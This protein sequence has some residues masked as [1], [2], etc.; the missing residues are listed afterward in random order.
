M[1]SV[2][3][4]EELHKTIWK[5]A[6]DL[7]GSVDGWDFKSYV[8][9]F[10]FYYF[11]CENLKSYVLNSFKQD[12]ENLSDEMAENGR[13][14]VINAKGFFIKPSH[15]FSNI[16]KNANLENLNEKLSVVFKEIE[17]SANGSES[18]KSFRGLFDDLDLYSNK[19]GADNK[20][21]NKKIL[22]IM[23]TISELDLHYNE[24]EIDAFGD[25]YE[26]LM[27]MYASNAGKSG[28]EFF[29][30]QEV[31]KLLVEITLHNNAKPNKVYDPACGSGS[32][33]LQYKKSLKSDPKKG[34]FGQE[35][36]ITTYN[37]ARMN[38]FLHDVN[39]TRFD[40]AH[41]DTLISPSENHKE[42]EPFDAIVSNPPY[43]TKWE[44]KDNALLINDERFNK[45][46]VLAPTSKA[47][48]AFV[49]HSLSW[50]SE[51]GSAAIVCFPGV[52]YRSG[53]EKE[54]RKYIIEE[55]F[56]DCVISLA[57]N[58]FFGTSIAVCILVLRK[59]KTD[60]NTLFINANEEFIKVTNK[61]MLSKENL[62]N[63]LNLYTDRVEVPHLSKLVS[64]EE[65][66]KNDYNLSVSS[67]VEVKDTRE[68]IDIKVL[69]KEIEEIVKRQSVLRNKIDSL[70]RELE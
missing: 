56:V 30:P 8:L 7:R 13:D 62:E 26:F 40:I 10:L 50:L 36:N 70:V 22:K 25:A 69:N 61:N 64:I 28:G 14:T 60:K 46:G 59:N 12:Y 1:K 2:V 57:P 43:S 5:I 27:T 11:I 4:R 63:I 58:L 29:T 45:A 67:Y 19:L 32:L 21:R 39:Y 37:L 33:L 23:E 55:N 53:A 54:I 6:N 48:L 47:D 66:A 3:E 18:E 9:G 24:N 17:S 49:M 44:G 68:I 41:G 16:F 38:M 15:L 42:L 34:Y 51:K 65:I 35:I 31:S 52:M 20:E